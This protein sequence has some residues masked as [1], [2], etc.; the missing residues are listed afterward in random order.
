MKLNK[1]NILRIF[2]IISVIILTL[3]SYIFHEFELLIIIFI[4]IGIPSLLLYKNTRI[5]PKLYFIVAILMIP[6]V[7][8]I[9]AF[10]SQ[11]YELINDK[12]YLYPMLAGAI[13]VFETAVIMKY[14][15]L[16][17][18][19][20]LIGQYKYEESLD[21]IEKFLK[22]NPGNYAG[23]FFKAQILGSLKR[24]QEQLD[25]SNMLI[26]KNKTIYQQN[27]N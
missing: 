20:R 14:S 19:I 11:H 7:S 21:V 6:I 25:L 5:N 4:F 2:A 16:R 12:T 10:L 13:C 24:Y 22:S 26:E 9:Y 3:L 18:A 27:Q 23:I 15:K 17:K 8:F 1:F